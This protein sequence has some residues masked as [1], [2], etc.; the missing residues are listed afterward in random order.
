[1]NALLLLTTLVCLSMQSVFRKIYAGRTGGGGVYTYT[2]IAGAGTLLFFI[3]TSKGF[4]W[5]ARIIPYAVI[6]AISYIVAGVFG[7]KAIA[8]GS[9]SLTSL[10]TN[11]SLILPTFYGLIFLSE[12]SSVFLY[13]GIILL[14][15][16]LVMVNKTGETT[17]V[18]GK[19]L[20][21]VSVAFI[22]NGMCS[23]SQKAQQDAFAG[24]GKNELMI[25]ALAIVV[26]VNFVFVLLTERKNL[27]SYVK[28]G[29]LNGLLGGAFN[30][31]VNLFVMFLVGRLPAS[32]VFPLISGGGIV[33]TYIISRVFYKEKLSRQQTIGFMLGIASIVLLNL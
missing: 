6:F 16:A 12:E 19:W 3:A 18:T 1:M 26:V 32:V 5:D 14:I 2:V 29:W 20:L 9:L 28:K 4:V 24:A 17:P 15:A 30:G 33:L 11:C 8:T 23:I 31:V 27:V 22:G 25:I 10:V 7:L 21:F 13:A